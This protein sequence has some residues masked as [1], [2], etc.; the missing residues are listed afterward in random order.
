MKKRVVQEPEV[1]LEINVD[2]L[3]RIIE[4]QV[5]YFGD[6]IKTLECWY[7]LMAEEDV[8]VMTSVDWLNLNHY[9]RVSLGNWY[10]MFNCGK[11]LPLSSLNCFKRL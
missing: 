10:Q 8:E 11:P 1:E 6:E 3:Q 4:R 5:R 2:S 7:L 9:D